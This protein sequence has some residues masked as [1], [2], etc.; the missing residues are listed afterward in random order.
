MKQITSG[1][2]LS[3]LRSQQLL[4]LLVFCSAL[5]RAWCRG[6]RRGQEVERAR[7][8]IEVTDDGVLLLRSLI[9]LEPHG[10][11]TVPME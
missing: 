7:G 1:M 6:R 11:Y 10:T 2:S 8:I 3:A 5:N 4:S 9:P